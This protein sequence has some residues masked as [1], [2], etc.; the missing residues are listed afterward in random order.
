MFKSKVRPINVPQYEH[1]RLAGTFASLWGNEDYD[2]PVIDFASFVQGVALH[3]SHY[4]IVD[5][6]PI[7]EANEADWLEMTRKRVEYWF[8]DPITD[9][10]AKLH[11]GRLLNRQESPETEGLINLIELRIAERLPHT[12]FSQE[13]FEWAD[14]I[15]RFCDR[16]AFD[17]SF[18]ASRENSRSVYAKA[19]SS[20]ET[21]II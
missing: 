18:E 20:K 13:Q 15:T 7:S 19:N 5:N 4:G 10:V 21:P 6:L 14:K 17:F 3:D 16:L 9:L 2:K 12:R 8:E 11:L 1:G